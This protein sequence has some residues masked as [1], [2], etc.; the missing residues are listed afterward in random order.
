[1]KR[2]IEIELRHTNENDLETF[3]LFQLDKE[4]NYLAA[5]TPKDPSDK[6]VYIKKWTQLLTDEKI[7]I[8]TILFEKE[9]V[10]SITK[11][12]MEG[13]AE[14]TYWID[15]KFWNKGIASNALKKFLEIEKTR[16]IYGRIAFDNVGSKKV[17]EHCGFTK[18][19]TERGFANARDKEIEEFIYKLT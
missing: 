7:N 10:G 14:I 4:A 2:A 16:P 17:L 15:K 1:M 6:D 13:D 9:I 5:F 11:F 18:V 19:G 3:F 12:E 8:R